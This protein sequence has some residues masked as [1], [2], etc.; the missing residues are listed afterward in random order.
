MKSFKALVQKRIQKYLTVVSALAFAVVVMAF[1]AG[2][3][4]AAPVTF[5]GVTLPFTVVDMLTTATNFLTMYGEWV[6]LALGVIFSPV[7]YG[8]AMKL[9]AA[10][11][12]KTA[13]K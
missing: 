1:G 4:M 5:T 12:A 13:A 3:S 6:L 8:L 2:E 11:K 7:L 10:A 9:V